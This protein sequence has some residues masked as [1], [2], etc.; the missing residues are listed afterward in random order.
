MESEGC[1]TW[2][3]D[4]S[5]LLNT[6]S[7]AFNEGKFTSPL[8]AQ[9]SSLW[10]G[11]ENIFTQREHVASLLVG[12]WRAVIIGQQSVSWLCAIGSYT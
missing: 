5:I 4:S 12:I 10:N 11:N 3:K 8:Q 9:F 6:H 1:V 2:G 7:D